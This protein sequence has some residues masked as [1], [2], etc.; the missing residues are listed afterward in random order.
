MDTYVCN[1]LVDFCNADTIAKIKNTEGKPVTTIRDLLYESEVLY[2]AC[3]LED[4]EK[5]HKHIGD[6]TLFISGIFPERLKYL[7]T[8]NMIHHPDR[9]IDHMKAGKRSYAIVAQHRSS[10]G[11]PDSSMYTLLSHEF[12]ASVVSLNSVRKKLDQMPATLETRGLI[13][14]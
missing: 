1:L 3:S 14:D 8:K 13:I 5:V 11:M 6:L 9:I 4:E 10:N 7:G 2:G 12:E